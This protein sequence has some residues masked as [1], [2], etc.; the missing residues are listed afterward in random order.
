MKI[1]P[2]IKKEKSFYLEVDLFKST[3]NE[4][5]DKIAANLIYEEDNLYLVA[6]E[7]L[8]SRNDS[9]DDDNKEITILGVSRSE[10]FMAIDPIFVGGG[11]SSSNVSTYKYFIPEMLINTHGEVLE[12]RKCSL[13]L[14]NFPLWLGIKRLIYGG[15]DEPNIFMEI[16]QIDDLKYEFTK[17]GETITL[18]FN[19]VYNTNEKNY[20][21]LEIQ[22]KTLIHIEPTNPKNKVWFNEIVQKT[23]DLF[24]LL[25]GVPL[26]VTYKNFH[27]ED[28]L[29]KVEY[30]HKGFSNSIRENLS[31]PMQLLFPYYVVNEQLPIIINNW[32]NIAN[33]DSKYKIIRLL[34]SNFYM[35]QYEESI[36]L[37]YMQGIEGFHRLFFGGGYVTEKEYREGK[38]KIN[39]FIDSEMQSWDSKLKKAV[40]DRIIYGYE[41]SL[42][43]RLEYLLQSL[44]KR[45]KKLFFK[46]EESIGEFVKEVKGLRNQLTHPNP[47]NEKSIKTGRLSEINQQLKILF[48][49]FIYIE[50][51]IS[52]DDIKKALTTSTKYRRQLSNYDKARPP[53]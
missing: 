4:D 39:K 8:P 10:K 9:F 53:F 16:N 18:I 30:Y 20:E 25:T 47:N 26:E 17:N 12:Y 48:M 27:I 29:P 40:K 36:F 13:E 41:F 45:V 22:H 32:F 11:F 35:K 51:N 31:H 14:S 46:D 2:S 6:R 7:K 38:R 44:D 33:D 37:N 52:S 19:P 28:M 34:I 23:V 43:D 24:V 5:F 50:L 3:E 42:G 21:Q 49:V 1:I 15:F